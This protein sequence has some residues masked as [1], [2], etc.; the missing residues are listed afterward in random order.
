MKRALCIWLPN[1]PLQRLATAREELR[2]QAVVLYQLQASGNA[3]VVA[4]GAHL[5]SASASPWDEDSQR[6]GG[7]RP[8]MPLAEATA[9]AGYTQSTGARLKAGGRRLEEATA[10]PLHLE[11]AD[12]L[13]DRLALEELA[14]WCQRFGPTVGLEEAV[15]PESLLLDVTGLGPL[16]GGEPALAER[17]VREFHLRNLTARV[18]IADTPGAAWA[19]AHYA[20]LEIPAAAHDLEPSEKPLP[21]PNSLSP[22]EMEPIPPSPLMGEGRGEGE[23]VS[24]RPPHPALSHDHASHGARRGALDRSLAAI[25]SALRV[26][27]VIPASHTWAALAPLPVEALRLPPQTCALLAE[28]GLRRIEQVAALPRAT[29]LSRF[30]PAVLEK[31]DRATGAAREAIAACQIPAELAFEWL[32]EHPTGRREMIEFA[33]A[34]LI[35]RACD[36]L[37]RERRGVLQLQCRFEYEQHSALQL[38]VGLYRPSASA[39]HVEDLVRLKLEGV[40]FREAVAAIRVAVLRIDRLEF[41]QQEMFAPEH[42]RESPRELAA[43]VDRLSNR[44]GPQAVLK[45]WLLASAQPEFACH[46]KPLTALIA[47]RRGRAR[48]A[49]Q[50]PVSIP[51]DRPLYL[52]PKP[53]SLSVMSVAPEGPPMQFRLAGRDERIVRAWGP[54]RI[55]TGWWRARCVRRDYYQ[56]ETTGGRRFWLFRQ[57]NT[58]RWYLHGEFA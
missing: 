37:A 5:A 22:G 44:L 1:W 46:Y 36:T 51:G 23:Y 19:V 52:E 25:L 29:L 7:I 40:R 38:I 34:Q 39:R 31:L 13:A 41:R 28:L 26:P 50:T 4:Y 20:D 11:M 14:E 32:F 2:S 10:L 58:G 35:A 15:P 24:P 33:L 43:L 48:S 56:A 45:P 42:C 49:P 3:R 16:V 18:A 53:L 55:E 30:G 9:L 8:G 6:T 17:V 57:L 21:H 27:L 12:P 54:E 47:R